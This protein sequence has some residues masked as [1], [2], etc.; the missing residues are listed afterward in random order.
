[1]WDKAQ[2]TEATSK[3]PPVSRTFRS[4]A[5]SSL[6]WRCKEQGIMLTDAGMRMFQTLHVPA[7]SQQL[8]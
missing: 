3:L 5:L 1:M 2:A 6:Q 8:T 7:G 4:C